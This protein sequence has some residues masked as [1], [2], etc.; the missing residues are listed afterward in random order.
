[1]PSPPEEVGTEEMWE[2]HHPQ[3][4]NRATSSRNKMEVRLDKDTNNFLPSLTVV[5]FPRPPN[6]QKMDNH[7]MLKNCIQYQY[8]LAEDRNTFLTK[9]SKRR[10]KIRR[11]MFVSFYITDGNC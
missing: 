2:T 4:K 11:T 7:L 9:Y 10:Y 5:Q 1:M 8:K 3:S 6:S